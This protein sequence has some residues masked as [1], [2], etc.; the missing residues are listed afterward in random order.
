MGL[1]SKVYGVFITALIF[2]LIGRFSKTKLIKKIG[3]AL[4]LFGLVLGIALI[5]G[6]IKLT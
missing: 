2:Y 3:V 5:T 1:L 4:F 6:M